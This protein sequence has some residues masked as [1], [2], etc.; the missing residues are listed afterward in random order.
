MME[1]FI[2]ALILGMIQGLTE[3]LPVS[4]SGHLVLFSNLLNFEVS[5]ITFDIFV[6]LG[7]LVSVLIV[8][9]KELSKMIVAPFAVWLQK[10]EDPELKEFLNWDIFV[11]V[12]TI[13]AVIVGLFFK[14]A[15]EQAF[16]SVLLVFFMLLITGLLM[17][18]T[19]FLKNQDKPFGY[20]NSF[21][22]GIAQAFAILPG[23]SRSGSTI[24]TGTALGI[25]R[26]K[27]AKFSFIMSIPAILGAAVLQFKDIL[28]T[29]P[30]STEFF[31][32]LAGGLMSAIT[33]YMA[34][35]WLIKIVERGRLQWFG[36]YCFA[37]GS[38]GII[39]Y[40]VH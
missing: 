31:T 3:F 25:D 8:F 27:A 37:V 30:T 1:Q 24:F 28:D 2:K 13:P 18:L 39:W 23:I 32:F 15:I 40:F 10:S 38:L 26:V 11:V 12:A 19:Q 20:A 34:I 6:H 22:I 14:D 7:T 16:T 29:P 36:Y 21:I 5:G 35:I 33:G 17:F 9:R 4:S